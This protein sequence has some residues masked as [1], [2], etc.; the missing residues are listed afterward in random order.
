MVLYVYC[1]SFLVLID[2]MRHKHK[3]AAA[4]RSIIAR[5]QTSKWNDDPTVRIRW[6]VDFVQLIF[7]LSLSCVY[8][9]VHKVSCCM[10]TMYDV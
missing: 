10:Y 1:D 3:K 5:S 7:S 4:F 9:I 6:Y 8:I 2:M